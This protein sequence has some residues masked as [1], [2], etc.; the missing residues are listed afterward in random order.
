MNVKH[1]FLMDRKINVQR[2]ESIRDICD[3]W[4]FISAY[5]RIAEHVEFYFAAVW[6]IEIENHN[7]D[8]D[9]A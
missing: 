8:N 3:Y 6:L 5:P 4:K 7:T 1:S 2:C 9:V